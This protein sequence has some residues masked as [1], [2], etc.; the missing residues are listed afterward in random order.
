VTKSTFIF[1]KAQENFERITMRRLIQ[2]RDGNPDSVQLWLA[3]L[4]KH[5]YYGIGMKANVWEF[6]SI[7][8]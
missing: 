7:G 6:S 5:A 3:F 1:K 8:G 2:I 4:Q